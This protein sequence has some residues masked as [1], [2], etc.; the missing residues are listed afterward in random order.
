MC[1]ELLSR[2]SPSAR[3]ECSTGKVRFTARASRM[4]GRQRYWH[5]RQSPDMQRNSDADNLSSTVGYMI[6]S[7]RELN[8]QEE[9]SIRF[10]F[11]AGD[12]RRHLAYK[13]LNR[14]FLI[15]HRFYF[16]PDGTFLGVFTPEPTEFT[17][18]DSSVV[19]QTPSSPQVCRGYSC[20]GATRAETG[21][22]RPDRLDTRN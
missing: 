2:A 17:R 8:E 20:N 4:Q 19:R 7:G 3:P 9:K 1:D 12:R 6:K 22:R 5:L 21:P 11:S 15:G 13:S 10:V 18:R 14:E 16:R